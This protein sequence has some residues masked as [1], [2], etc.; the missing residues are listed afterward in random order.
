MSEL[1]NNL[2]EWQPLTVVRRRHDRARRELIENRRDP[3]HVLSR[4]STIRPNLDRTRCV[5]SPYSISLLDLAK[6][7]IPYGVRSFGKTR[8]LMLWTV[9][10]Y[11]SPWPFSQKIAVVGANNWRYRQDS[12][13]LLGDRQ[14]SNQLLKPS[15][16]GGGIRNLAHHWHTGPALFSANR[17][18]R[19][20]GNQ[21]LHASIP[22]FEWALLEVPAAP[23]L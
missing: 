14:A 23:N 9:G 7:L 17:H 1:L 20:I 5:L 12:H 16:A 3:R 18:F 19:A 6:W 11:R 15:L 8:P 13:P 22:M 21:S 2:H 4:R 10:P